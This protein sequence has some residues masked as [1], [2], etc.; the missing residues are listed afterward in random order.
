VQSTIKNIGKITAF[1]L[2][3]LSPFWICRF[4]LL[5]L[6]PDLAVQNVSNYLLYA[7]RFDLKALTIWYSPLLIISFVGLFY[8]VKRWQFISTVVFAI[9]YLSAL[10]FGLIAVFYFEISKT[11][12]GIE[13]F[14]LLIGQSPTVLFGYATDF[15]WAVLLSMLILFGLLELEKRIRTNM[16]TKQSLITSSLL[17]LLILFF[18]RG[19]LALKPLNLMDAY[20]NL[21]NREAI[22]AV[23]PVYVL[24]ESIGKKNIRYEEYIDENTLKNKLAEEHLVLTSPKCVRPNVC[25]I[26]L[27]S[28]GKE[29]TQLNRSGRPSYTPFLDSLMSVSQCYTNAYANGLRSMDV[30][31]SIYCGVPSFMKRP[32][33]GSLYTNSAIASLPLSLREKGYYTSFFH[34]ADEL[35]MGFKPFLLAQGLNNYSG[36]QQYP[37]EKDYDGTWGIFDEPFLQY[38]AKKIGEQ[39]QPWFS[40]VFTLSSHHPYTVP[41]AYSSLP[42]GT[43]AIHQSVGYTDAALRKFF[44]TAV[45]QSWFENT[46]FIITADHTSINQTPAYTNYRGKY[47]VPLVVYGKNIPPAIDSSIVNHIDLFPTIKSLAGV[48]KTT[49]FGKQL[50]DST[51][52]YSFQYDGNVYVCTSD[53]FSLVWNGSADPGLFAYKLDPGHTMD[54]QKMYPKVASEMLHSLKVFRQKYN[55]RLLNNDFK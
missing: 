39:E 52:N 36:R 15:W 54:I 9:L 51:G 42:K 47:A 27:E 50:N 18:A 4:V 30:V 26:L 24:I 37:N 13:L 12:V 44:A 14:Q 43:A 32:F 8:K 41:S 6:Y 25:L 48:E 45:K 23:T 2:L 40:G 10:V 28:F 17:L 3:L 1:V 21:S 31:A 46:V 35:S 5:S 38:F 53:S 7:I 49:A 22:S 20:G 34:G 33:I 11:I 19:G 29:Y 55:Y 16:R